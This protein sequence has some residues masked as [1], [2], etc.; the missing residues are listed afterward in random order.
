MLL[1]EDDFEDSELIQRSFSRIS[2]EMFDVH[3]VGRFRDAIQ[4]I[5]TNSSNVV[6]LDMGLPDSVG[7]NEVE[8]LVSLIPQVP[9]IVLTGFNNED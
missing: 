5:K 4:I 9:V 3:H 1:I 2:E 6:I 7:L 8:R